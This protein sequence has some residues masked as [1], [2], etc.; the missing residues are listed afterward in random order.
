[1]GNL[2]F[3][4]GLIAV[5][6]GITY[7]IQPYGGHTMGWTSPVVLGLIGGGLA[8]LAGFCV[9][10][11]AFDFAIAA[12]LVAAVASLLRGRRYVHEEQQ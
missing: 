4:A 6:V 8:V 7:G 10:D 3:A 1:V 5:L 2:T 12:C 11:I 9:I